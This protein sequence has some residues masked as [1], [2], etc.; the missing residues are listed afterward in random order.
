[1]LLGHAAQRPKGILLA[2]GKRSETLA[3]K[4]DAA[5]LE[6]EEGEAKVVESVSKRL[7][8]SSSAN[9]R[10][11]PETVTPSRRLPD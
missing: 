8:A 4:H 10:W 1:M 9:A 11:A 6:A 2:L 7:A 3:A 5:M